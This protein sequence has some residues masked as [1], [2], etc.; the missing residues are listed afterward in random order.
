M[1]YKSDF[2]AGLLETDSLER[3]IFLMERISA[4]DSR[5]FNTLLGMYMDIVFRF[6]YSFLKNASLA[7]DITQEVFVKLWQKPDSWK[8]TGRVR[9]WLLRLA[10]NLSIDELR[11]ENKYTDIDDEAIAAIPSYKNLPD[12][13]MQKNFVRD[14]LKDAV[15]TLPERQKAAVML[16]YYSGCSN[17]EGAEILGVSVEAFESL[18]ARAKR[19][20]KEMLDGI[21][22][23]L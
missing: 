9:S 13:V 21:K 15:L 1:A 12:D 10:H 19:K 6:C 11:K 8:P 4:K 7:E 23:D 14:T 2:D 16:S 18:L 5:A 3:D 22:E 20:L 17:K